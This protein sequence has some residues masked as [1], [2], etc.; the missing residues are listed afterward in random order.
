MSSSNTVYIRFSTQEALYSKENLIDFQINLV[1]LLRIIQKY[2][3]YKKEDVVIKTKIMKGF[4][5][6]KKN[7]TS[8]D[9]E[10]PKTK[11]FKEKEEELTL[12]TLSQIEE[13]KDKVLIDLQKQLEGVRSKIRAF[14]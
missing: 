13:G 11:E 4:Q 8:L 7:L 14:G 1:K 12:N 3:L 6:I 10:L 9:K 5:E 2:R